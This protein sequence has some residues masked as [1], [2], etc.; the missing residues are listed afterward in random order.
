MITKKGR[1]KSANI[2][3]RLTASSQFLKAT[4]EKCALRRNEMCECLANEKIAVS[5]QV[6]PFSSVETHQSTRRHTTEYC[7]LDTYRHQNLQS[8]LRKGQLFASNTLKRQV[9]LL[10][11]FIRDAVSVSDYI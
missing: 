4:G 6:T 2:I 3:I 7:N 10:M 9:V 11:F 8:Y 1:D 5:W